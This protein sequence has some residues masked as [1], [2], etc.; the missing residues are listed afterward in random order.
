MHS[1]STAAL[2]GFPTGSCRRYPQVHHPPHQQQV[3]TRFSNQCKNPSSILTLSLLQSL[4]RLR[5]TFGITCCRLLW[6]FLKIKS[7]D[8]NLQVEN[9][10]AGRGFVSGR[11][12]IGLRPALLIWLGSFTG[13]TGLGTSVSTAAVFCFFLFFLRFAILVNI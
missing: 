13:P 1:T 9:F 10:S 5:A 7:F 6:K 2:A 8:V 12:G 3:V 4:Q 11:G